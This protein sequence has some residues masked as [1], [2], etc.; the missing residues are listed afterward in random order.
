MRAQ[1]FGHMYGSIAS[2]HWVIDAHMNS[3]NDSFNKISIQLLN[4]VSLFDLRQL[5]ETDWH[6]FGTT[7][8]SDGLM[9]LIVA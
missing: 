1:Y 5:C 3:R 8:D 6:A 9:R 7:F 4:A 2:T